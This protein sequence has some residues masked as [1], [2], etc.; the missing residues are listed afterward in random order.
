MHKINGYALSENLE[1]VQIFFT[2][3]K[4][5][6]DVQKTYK[7][8]VDGAVSQST[9]FLKNA[10]NR[11]FEEMEPTAPAFDFARELANNENNIQR[12]E[13]FIIT[14]GECDISKPDDQQIR[15]VLVMYR[16]IDLCYLM[17]L[18]SGQ[19]EPIEIDFEELYGQSIPCLTIPI[20]N[21]DYQSFLAVV[22]GNLLAD[23]YK[24]YGSRLLEMNVR[25]FLQFM[26][27][28][29]KGIR[30]TILKEPHM[31]LAYNNGIAAT[32]QDVEIVDLPE[33]GKGIKSVR[34][35][36]IVNGG[37]TTASILSTRHKDKANI[38][39]VFV[40]MKLSVI[41]N[42]NEINTIVNRISRYANS[43]NKVSDAD[44][45]AN[46]PF[47]IEIE[48]LSRI[49][50]APPL[51]GSGYQTRWFYERARGQYR[52]ELAKEVTKKQKA[53]FTAQ[54]PKN[55]VLVKED[56]AKYMNLWAMLPF[57]VVRG[58]Q[59]N[60]AVFM[61]SLKKNKLKADNIFFED[62]VAKA[63]LFR[64]SEKIYGIKPN[65]LGDMRY[66]TVPYTIAYLNQTTD[67]R[68]D[69]LKIWKQQRLSDSLCEQL[70]ELMIQIEGFI[71]KRAPGSLYGE[72]AKKEDCWKAV[73]EQK[74]SLKIQNI[75]ADLA[76]E[77][78]LKRRQILTDEEA[79]EMI[80]E[81]KEEYLRGISAKIWNDIDNWG[82]VTGKLTSHQRTIVYN[83]ATKI[84]SNR[85][86]LES[87][88]QHGPEII[89]IVMD[90]APEFF[91]IADENLIELSS[92][93]V[94][95]NGVQITLEDVKNLVKWDKKHR[96]LKP[97]HYL[98]MR[99][100][101]EGR[102]PMSEQNLKIIQTNIDRLKNYGFE[103]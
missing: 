45:T 4:G 58:N 100:I 7:T 42:H 79:S 89:E 87:E 96:R 97:H 81:Q 77:D 3:Y 6:D 85:P 64:T 36:Q 101:A 88:L 73:S 8:E 80:I 62:L 5:G 1:T 67:G 78:S 63:I 90:H 47:H 25:S 65:A 20:A 30:E 28:I 49:I 84:K 70:R 2:L 55:Q 86:F 41:K 13:I 92:N 24:R 76:T 82:R 74:F 95:E 35:L 69:L 50:W 71:K 72:W 102:R 60:Y 57:H 34:E 21:E 93:I 38:D 18:E 66:L 32:A 14:D 16:V 39:Q 59:K 98:Y 91:E 61:N 29:N 99:D 9:R 40:Q 12:A 17:R 19:Q 37:Q 27:K 54:N 23:V 11:Y 15:N 33:G 53:A 31:F 68:L 56:L 52:N 103:L 75:K 10:L 22:P 48:K 51:P 46:S 44:L 94:T 83:I 43:Q 26:G